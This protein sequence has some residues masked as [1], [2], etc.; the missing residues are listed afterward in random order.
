MLG[1][2]MSNQDED[3]VE[4]ELENLEREVAGIPALPEAPNAVQEGM[5]DAPQESPAERQR[6]RRKE[7]A[8]KEQAS[9]P[10]AA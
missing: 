7:R 10:I 3:E 5:P 6:R 2:K 4:D 9:E 8:A 1:N